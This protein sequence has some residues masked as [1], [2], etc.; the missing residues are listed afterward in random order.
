MEGHVV[1]GV[2]VEGGGVHVTL[3]AG[4]WVV[5]GMVHS[6]LCMEEG[7]RETEETGAQNIQFRVLLL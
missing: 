6:P 1:V 2:C 4:G 5:G 7:E 3:W